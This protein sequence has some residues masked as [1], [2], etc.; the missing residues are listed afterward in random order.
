MPMISG[1]PGFSGDCFAGGGGLDSGVGAG[2]GVDFGARLPDWA[3]TV[4]AQIRSKPG[5]VTSAKLGPCPL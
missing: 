4:N 3:N 5:T 1:S 2:T